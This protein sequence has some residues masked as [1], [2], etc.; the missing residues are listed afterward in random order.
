MKEKISCMM[1]KRK[2]RCWGELKALNSWDEFAEIMCVK[3]G[4]FYTINFLSMFTNGNEVINN[5]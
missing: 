4:S 5:E 2:M 1:R 3:C